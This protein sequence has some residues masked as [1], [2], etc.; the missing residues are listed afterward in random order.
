MRFQLLSLQ[1]TLTL[2]ICMLTTL[3]SLKPRRPVPKAE[4]TVTGYILVWTF[5]MYLLEPIIDH[6]ITFSTPSLHPIKRNPC[7]SLHT[8][9][10][11][12]PCVLQGGSGT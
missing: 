6:V 1:S 3:I 5:K 4:G 8:L 10:C 2:V 11:K 12:A 9:E 7:K